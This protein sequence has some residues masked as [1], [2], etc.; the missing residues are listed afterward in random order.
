VASFMELEAWRALFFFL[1]RVHSN[2]R[3]KQGQERE[4]EEPRG[5]E[6]HSSEA[7][8]RPRFMPLLG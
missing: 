1:G 4:P 3:I 2:K 8:Q 6:T 5:E 7:A